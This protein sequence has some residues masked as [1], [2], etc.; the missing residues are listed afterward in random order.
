LYQKFITKKGKKIGP[1]FYESI[2]LK[3]GK[4]K[5]V[6]LGSNEQVALQKLQGLHQQY[7]LP[8]QLS[9]HQQPP[10]QVL[11]PLHQLREQIQVYE[12]QQSDLKTKYSFLKRQYKK[13]I[14]STELFNQRYNA[15]FG[16]MGH[17]LTFIHYDSEISR[18]EQEILHIIAAQREQQAP[19]EQPQRD[20]PAK[21][22]LTIPFSPLLITSLL[23]LLFFSF[24]QPSLIGLSFL[25]S[26]QPSTLEPLNLVTNISTTYTLNLPPGTQLQSLKVSGSYQEQEGSSVRIYLVNDNYLIYDSQRE[27]PSLMERLSATLSSFFS[28]ITGMAVVTPTQTS[29]FVMNTSW[30]E[31][32]TS[33]FQE[34][35]NLTLFI[36]QSPVSSLF[37]HAVAGSSLMMTDQA[38]VL[39]PPNN[40]FFIKFYAF[41][42]TELNFT[43]GSFTSTAEGTSLY[44][45]SF[46]DLESGL[47]LA[48][49]EEVLNLTSGMDYTFQLSQG[50]SA[51]AEAS[52]TPREQNIS[53][54]ETL[55]APEPPAL[56]TIL[57]ENQ[58]FFSSVCI[59]TCS[60]ANFTEP[61]YKL[62]IIVTNTTLNLSS[63]EYT[64]LA[65]QTNQQ[66]PQRRMQSPLLEDLLRQKQR[67][68]TFSA[69][70]Q[71]LPVH[72]LRQTPW[73]LPAGI[74]AADNWEK[75]CEG[76]DCVQTVYFRDKYFV[77]DDDSVE[78][79]ENALETNCDGISDVCAR[80][81]K[82][83]ADFKQTPLED[84]TIVFSRDDIKIAFQPLQIRYVTDTQESLL[85][86]ANP[87]YGYGEKNTLTYDKIFGLGTQMR[88]T[89]EPNFLK[90]EVI[91][92][93]KSLLRNN[94]IQS[95]DGYLSIDYLVNLT[96]NLSFV[97]ST[98]PI[99]PQLHELYV[100][101]SSPL[102][103]PSENIAVLPQPFVASSDDYQLID[104]S[105]LQTA[106][107][108][109]LSLRVPVSFLQQ[110]TYPV[111]VDPTVTLNH[112]KILF[113]GHVS[114]D[115]EALC[116]DRYTTGA[117]LLI[118]NRN[119]D[120]STCAGNLATT[121]RADIEWDITSVDR[122]ADITDVNL[123]LYVETLSVS[124][125]TFEF[126]K[127]DANNTFYPN[128]DSGNSNFYTDMG[129]G[130]NY[131]SSSVNTLGAWNFNLTQS[132]QLAPDL[133]TIL[134]AQRGWWNIGIKTEEIGSDKAYYVTSTEG[135]LLNSP[136]LMIQ[137]SL[138]VPSIF[139]NEL[140][141]TSVVHRL[142]D[143]L[144]NATVYDNEPQIQE[145]VF[146][147]SNKTV[148]D[149]DDIVHI[150]LNVS[151]ASGA[152]LNWTA[153][154]WE[155][156][157]Y[158]NLLLHFNN[159][160]I[161]GE[162]DTYVVDYS[163]NS[164]NGTIIP[165]GV[166][167]DRLTFYNFTG[168]QLGAG[169][170]FK[171]SGPTPLPDPP[172]TF[173]DEN[174]SFGD[175]DELIGLD[176]TWLFWTRISN[177]STMGDLLTKMSGTTGFKVTQEKTNLV[178]TAN[179]N[180]INIS[181]FFF[182]HDMT[183]LAITLDS[184]SI[185]SIYKNGTLVNF[186]EGISITPNNAP[187]E[188]LILGQEVVFE[189]VLDE[190]VV[191]NRSLNAEEVMR[192]YQL[193]PG[194]YYWF[195]NATDDSGEPLGVNMSDIF[196]FTF[197]PIPYAILS[198]PPNGTIIRPSFIDVILNT[199]VYS[200]ANNALTVKI[201]GDNTSSP[202]GES[203]LYMEENVANGTEI[204]YNWTSPV[205]INGSGTMVLLHLDNRS[206]FNE[207]DTFFYD[208]SGQNNNVTCSGSNCLAFF[209]LNLTGGKFA[210]GLEFKG[211]TPGGAP[212]D[213]SDASYFDQLPLTVET[214]V[215]FYTLPSE[216]GN[217]GSSVQI[218]ATK[219]HVPSPSS[220][221]L[222]I[223][224]GTG[225]AADNIVFS[226][227]NSTNSTSFQ[228]SYSP[229]VE[230]NAWYHLVA[231]GES[232]GT[233][234]LYVNGEKIP[235]TI[236]SDI[237]N[238]T[239]TLR[240][241]G[242][243]TSQ[244]L[245]GTIDEFIF[246]NRALS[247]SEVTTHY[248]LGR[249]TYYWYANVSDGTYENQSETF[250]FPINSQP[251]VSVGPTL[252]PTN[253][254]TTDT[255]TCTFT[256]TDDDPDDILTYNGNF[257]NI[258]SGDFQTFSG[259]TTNGT[260]TPQSAS[261]DIQG[262]NDL[263]TC[264]V[265]P[266]DGKEEGTIGTSSTVQVLNSPPN[267][268]SLT[269]PEH[270]NETFNRTPSFDYGTTTD[271]DDD[272]L[273][274]TLNLTCLSTSGGSCT[275]IGD[276]RI[277]NYTSNVSALGQELAYFIDD[278]LF[279][280]WTV[281]ATDGENDSDWAEPG[282]SINIS[283]F[284]SLVLTSRTVDFKTAVVGQ[285]NETYC[286]PA[287]PVEQTVPSLVLENT[288]NVE[289]DV[290][291]SENS[292]SSLFS[293]TPAPTNNYLFY[294]EVPEDEGSLGVTF[295]SNSTTS[296]T[297]IPRSDGTANATALQDFNHTNIND[298]A[299]IMINITV[300][301]DEPSGYKESMLEF[302]GYYRSSFL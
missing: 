265:T 292:T 221:T 74:E 280:N 188:L 43:E 2:R 166:S 115:I 140:A 150:A 194:T 41:N 187:F 5:T 200:D 178:I 1:Y 278:T 270:L 23:F 14:I 266:S 79:L 45:C 219:L 60:I 170:G 69:E 243:P 78:L 216:N 129:D 253:A 62:V 255:F 112:T 165:N 53:S 186:S 130:T 92:S 288:G 61:E 212:F 201:F 228:L 172:P 297:Q 163:D 58:T 57:L 167:I 211:A 247:S 210:G 173:E 139:L 125:S 65:P 94:N 207:N 263:F 202:S 238:S 260:S 273:N 4:V 156:D 281:L 203:L 104:Y 196:T 122:N 93:D 116:Y 199:T 154:V 245:N 121:N 67:K 241:G 22:I 81:K 269:G 176:Y 39:T 136:V 66:A 256:I 89:V 109:I 102:D 193:D 8:E 113:D 46:W 117:Q 97:S 120:V 137:Y 118:G 158:T 82:Y 250:Q 71:T 226:V 96:G 296:R 299:C 161:Y 289:I 233:F 124:E 254:N 128:D 175:K 271:P 50:I 227:A 195:V 132:A 143:I 177:T 77:K 9:H 127:M 30:N 63:L 51:F 7:G 157:Q 236:Q 100:F 70:N 291:I 232:N 98:G 261:G 35:N 191:L 146:F 264:D 142:E 54:N 217:N 80:G 242:S 192:S 145:V 75:R 32:P 29:F 274:Y 206:E 73:Q 12:Q 144:L 27:R 107:G 17:T 24:F 13:N 240:L 141:N 88:I 59:D 294:V 198:T 133:E 95:T 64:I 160:S 152:E 90:E 52:L 68:I 258:S 244:P 190:F 267:T 237:F 302:I 251:T 234:S 159:R 189:G 6:Y 85:S 181:N 123:T 138:P 83:R 19:Q 147:A 272:T 36:N 108:L 287:I 174:I 105:L 276:D 151:N 239:F 101:N 185:M 224:D 149:G 284:V 56:E 86:S 168:A 257:N 91:F 76:N 135:S 252:T 16:D 184:S 283:T 215:K 155:K 205:A 259:A 209:N 84:E 218:I 248:S 275:G 114:F 235:T 179:T 99:T 204:K 103:S 20:S 38:Q 25:S 72:K 277:L 220:W 37:F 171:D 148:P 87:I 268:V 180:V 153:P 262:K 55:S 286:P 183:Q 110:A 3:D 134:W 34:E 290:N 48:S 126:Y 300:P 26:E 222:A 106:E 182:D 49:W 21:K 42:L 18:L 293:S 164:F 230:K 229:P 279:Y 169:M 282:R 214:W 28:G 119:D 40:L 31:L 213:I 208:F 197:S 15:L 231:V 246:Y 10:Q 44:R 285:S 298:A 47:C 225:D 111:V 295:S 131:L 33:A 301:S 11:S 249:Q 162:N 223:R